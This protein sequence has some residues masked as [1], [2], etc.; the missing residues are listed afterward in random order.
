MNSNERMPSAE[1]SKSPEAEK[2]KYSISQF[3]AHQIDKSDFVGWERMNNGVMNKVREKVPNLNNPTNEEGASPQQYEVSFTVPEAGNVA[4]VLAQ[5]QAE[6][7]SRLRD[8]SFQGPD[9]VMG[10]VNQLRAVSAKI[11]ASFINSK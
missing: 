6:R 8:K 1:V 10:M 4:R 11:E 5:E 2:E 7:L 3:G 9:V